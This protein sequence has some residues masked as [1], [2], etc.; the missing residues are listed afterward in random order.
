MTFLSEHLKGISI[1]L[2][3]LEPVANA[4]GNELARFGPVGRRTLGSW[5]SARSHITP[6]ATLS[7]RFVCLQADNWVQVI[8]DGRNDNAYVDARNVA[9]RLTCDAVCAVASD[10][11]RQFALFRSGK[12]IRTIAAYQDGDRWSFGQTGE[13]QE[14][15]EPA[16]YEKSSIRER[17]TPSMV[18][19]YLKSAGAKQFPVEWS[20]LNTLRGVALSRSTNQLKNP[21]LPVETELD[22]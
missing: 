19:D 15:E 8:A 3:E 12:E 21:V 9:R 4:L 20:S 1:L 2:A 7:T 16:R 10:D 18:L 6:L 11:M 22:V 13:I 5:T 14:W 17:L